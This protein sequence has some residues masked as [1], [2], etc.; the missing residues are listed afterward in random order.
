MNLERGRE[1]EA[2]MSCDGV[3]NG[4]I[5]RLFHL[6]STEQL[7]TKTK[8][9]HRIQ[10]YL[11]ARSHSTSCTDNSCGINKLHCFKKEREEGGE[12][13]KGRGYDLEE[14]EEEVNEQ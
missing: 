12:R 6:L 5:P 11:C 14:R 8:Q 9:G 3:D 10:M 4:T 7:R 2:L 1:R 13:D